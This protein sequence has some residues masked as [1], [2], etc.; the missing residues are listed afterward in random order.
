MIIG[1]SYISFVASPAEFDVIGVISF[2]QPTFNNLF[3]T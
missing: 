3:V 2:S 1:K